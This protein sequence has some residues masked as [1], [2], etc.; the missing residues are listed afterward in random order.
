MEEEEDEEIIPG[1]PHDDR[2]NLIP[3]YEVE[4]IETD[5]DFVMQRYTTIRINDEYYIL[6]GKDDSVIRSKSN[7]NYCGLTVNGVVFLNRSK[8]PYSLILK[9]AS[10]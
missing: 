1:K 6:R 2:G 5:E 4:W 3:V 7:P 8:E 10:L 9:C